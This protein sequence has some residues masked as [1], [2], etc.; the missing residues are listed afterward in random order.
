MDAE[1]EQ[2]NINIKERIIELIK[3]K[4]PIIPVQISKETNLDIL[5]SSAHLS[6]LSSER[7]VKISNIK[8]G[9]SPL[10]YLPGQ[11]AYLQNFSD[12]L[13]EKEK[14]AFDI[15]RERKVLRESKLEPVIRVALRE[16]KDFAIP[17][18][19]TYKNNTEIFWKWYLLSKEEA[20][21][22]IK[23]LLTKKEQ[24]QI[25]T[26]KEI[27]SYET[28]IKKPA[29][30]KETKKPVEE[31]PREIKG[32]D[33]TFSFL[34]ETKSYFNK[35]KITIKNSEII[36]KNS[37]IDFILEVP[38]AVGNLEYYCKAKNKKRVNDGDLSSAYV[39]GQLKKMPVLFL[40]K[41]GLTKRAKE[42]L[43]KE[44]KNMHINQI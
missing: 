20:S 5:M 42:M 9:G 17:L 13:H 6:E 37:E 4:G 11:E 34:E 24:P 23:A 44:F 29:I 21:S 43:N 31:K 32:T 28:E 12:N 40:T 7:K 27:K 38:S 15:L 41:G 18:Q 39:Q 3:I 1:I 14:K 30:K 2:K 36:R 8:I 22:L 19:V 10:Y 35:N 33:K 25:D 26:K 16:I